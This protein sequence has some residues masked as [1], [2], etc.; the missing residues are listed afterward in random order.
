MTLSE[1]SSLLIELDRLGSI[2]RQS[3]DVNIKATGHLLFVLEVALQAGLSEAMLRREAPSAEATL[4]ITRA[5]AGKGEW[6]PVH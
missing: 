3:T 1:K 2:A 4:L 5:V 6:G